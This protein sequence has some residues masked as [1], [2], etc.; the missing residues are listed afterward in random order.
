MIKGTLL[1]FL[2]LLISPCFWR[3]E[4]ICTFEQVA[5]APCILNAFVVIEQKANLLISLQSIYIFIFSRTRML[6]YMFVY[7]YFGSFRGLENFDNSSLAWKRSLFQKPKRAWCS[8]DA[9]F[10]L[11]SSARIRM[12]MNKQAIPVLRY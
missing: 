1:C 4:C 2:K 11:L 9:R 7:I 3:H 6:A 5:Y 10:Y 12:Y 8:N